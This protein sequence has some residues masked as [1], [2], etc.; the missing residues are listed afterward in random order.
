MNVSRPILTRLHKAKILCAALGI[1]IVLTNGGMSSMG[2]HTTS[3]APP[4]R[5]AFQLYTDILNAAETSTGRIAVKFKEFG[6]RTAASN[7]EQSAFW[8]IPANDAQIRFDLRNGR[9]ETLIID[10]GD[11]P[12]IITFAEGTR[13]PGT[14]QVRKI[15]YNKDG[16]VRDLFEI[17][18]GPAITS[19]VR[20]GLGFSVPISRFTETLS[21][22][23][24]SPDLAGLLTAESFAGPLKL[25]SIAVN[26]NGE[27]NLRLVLRS[28]LNIPLGDSSGG[29]NVN[30]VSFS[31]RVP[32]SFSSLRYE[33]TLKNLNATIDEFDA[34]LTNGFIDTGET[35]LKLGAESLLQS[36]QIRFSERNG[37]DSFLS[38]GARRI[39]GS[40]L[41]GSNLHLSQAGDRSSAVSVGAASVFKGNS[42]NFEIKGDGTKSLSLTDNTFNLV[43]ANGVLSPD[44]NNFFIFKT[45]AAD[46]TI[47]RGRWSGNSPPDV[48]GWLSPAQLELT[49]GGLSF[50]STN[51]FLIGSGT[52]ETGELNIDTTR[53]TIITG[54]VRPRALVFTDESFIGTVNRFQ[55]NAGGSLTENPQNLLSF[56]RES[57][58]LHGRILFKITDP[59]GRIDFGDN[60]AVT[61]ISGQVDTIISKLPGENFNGELRGSLNIGSGKIPLGTNAVAGVRSGKLDFD[62]LIFSDVN[63]LAGAF[64]SLRI[65]P[66]GS[67]TQLSQFF[68]FLPGGESSIDPDSPATAVELTESGLKGPLRIAASFDNGEAK[69]AAGGAFQL[70]RGNITGTINASAGNP[71][72][73]NI[74]LASGLSGGSLDLDS[75]TRLMLAPGSEI[76][77]D[78]LRLSEDG[79]LSGA[80]SRANFVLN[81]GAMLTAIRG[82]RLSVIAGSSFQTGSTD[83]LVFPANESSPSGSGRLTVMFS[84]LFYPSPPG[85]S[86]NNGELRAE[87]TRNTGGAIE[88]KNLAIKGRQKGSYRS[89]SE[90]PDDEYTVISR[91]SSNLIES[92]SAPNRVMVVNSVPIAIGT[93]ATFTDTGLLS[94]AILSEDI[95]IFGVPL[96]GGS[97]VEVDAQNSQVLIG[98]IGRDTTIDG[99]P[100]SKGCLA[101]LPPTPLDRQVPPCE[102]IRTLAFR[103]KTSNDTFSGAYAP[104]TNIKLWPIGDLLKES[105]DDIWID[106]GPQAWRIPFDSKLSGNM[107]I[108]GDFHTGETATVEILNPAI[109]EGGNCSALDGPDVPLYVGDIRGIRVEK[110]G[111]FVPVICGLAEGPDSDIDLVLNPLKP[112]DPRDI[113]K[114]LNAAIQLKRQ[115]LGLKNS[116]LTALQPAI[117]EAGRLIRE[118]GQKEEKLAEFRSTLIEKRRQVGE[119]VC[120]RLCPQVCVPVPT[121]CPPRARLECA[122]GPCP[123]KQPCKDLNNAIAQLEQDIRT[124]E[125]W[126]RDHVIEKAAAVAV[127]ATKLALEAEI[128]LFNAVVDAVQPVADKLQDYIDRL[129]PD[130]NIPLPGQWQPESVTIVVNGRDLS[131]FTINKRLRQNDSFWDQPIRPM[132]SAEYFVQG[133]RVNIMKGDG[134]DDYMSF[135]A[136]PGAKMRGFTGWDIIEELKEV[137]IR[138]VLKHPPGFGLDAGVSLDLKVDQVDIGLRRFILDGTKGIRHDRYIR[139]EYR[140]GTDERWRNWHPGDVIEVKGSIK[141]DRDKNTFYEIHPTGQSDINKVG[142]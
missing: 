67:E 120:E 68:H 54:E 53:R 98:T 14:L 101:H 50:N 35:K 113:L 115:E 108:S 141:R 99:I 3:S 130:I 57:E 85:I 17:R 43:T 30:F 79:N 2:A 45:R 105:K 142:P 94:R 34:R 81:P 84:D 107:R 51:S 140:F 117:E 41:A 22:L 71:V 77:T 80:V 76:T 122:E 125:S 31:E 5:F 97:P 103:I 4:Q 32:L 27:E 106:I 72:T 90:M 118:I 62:K 73:G 121:C 93:G 63:G 19:I 82:R 64:T 116:A 21:H 59:A 16:T 28:G 83:P 46:F 39:E 13:N 60:R 112:P 29:S 111:I 137:K 10:F 7:A 135:I 12:I 104:L 20:S 78:V 40:L 133:L 49:G 92:I 134:S 96:L 65:G 42:F 126:L 138:G 114:N 24:L 66:G 33:P 139:V 91:Y 70:A 136:T 74:R 58:G 87:Y 100:Y 48:E 69:T 52:L 18:N 102:L 37:D 86:L 36:A 128:K 89:V 132:S 8:R 44:S 23:K 55:L 38:L 75:S 9:W 56:S 123:W 95:T 110:K 129:I 25:D 15:S 11:R 1:Y 61:I 6:G 127:L 47:S 88:W 109:G 26:R 131:T 124:Y 119:F